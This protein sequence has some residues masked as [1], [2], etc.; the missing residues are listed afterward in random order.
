MYCWK[1]GY[2]RGS[3]EKDLGSKFGVYCGLWE[4][5]KRRDCFCFEF[6]N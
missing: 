2:K 3:V 4:F 6:F 1:G 5:R